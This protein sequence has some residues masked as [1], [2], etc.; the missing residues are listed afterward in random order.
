MTVEEATCRNSQV[1][2]LLRSKVEAGPES[3][4]ATTDKRRFPNHYGH[5]RDAG[6]TH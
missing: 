1:L 5:D 6:N 2:A 4:G 3:V